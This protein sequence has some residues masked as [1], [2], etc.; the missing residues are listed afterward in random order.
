MASLQQLLSGR[1]ERFTRNG[2]GSFQARCPACAA[3]GRDKTG[4]H[5]RVWANGAFHCIVGSDEGDGASEHNRAIR[6]FLHDGLDPTSLAVLEVVV[7]D[8]D[9]KLTADPIYPEAML[10]RLVPDHRYW[11]GRHISE[12]VLRRYEGGLVPALP[13]NK[14]AGRYVLPIRCATTRRIMGWTGRLVSDASFGP[15]WKHLVKSKRAVYPLVAHE[16]AIRKARKVV[17]VESVGDML[18]C[19]T[20]GID[21]TLVLLGLHLNS[22]VLGFMVAANLEVVISTNTDEAK[23]APNGTIIY[24]GQDAAA[25]LRAKLVPY[26][27]E[28]RVSVRLPTTPGCKDWNDVLRGG[29]AHGVDADH[30]AELEGGA[31]LAAPEVVAP[32]QSPEP[33]T[34]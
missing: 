6:A 29:G 13:R 30:V 21:C 18:S 17:L 34:L 20:A 32:T 19:A 33:F 15:A 26:L 31:P 25:K 2:D 16:A 24:P 3:Q 1:L 11:V 14:L 8:P 10:Q 23:V 28:A 27:G 7:V 9:P 12:D 5:L 22:R 4:E